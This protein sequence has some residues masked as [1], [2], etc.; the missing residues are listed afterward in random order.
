MYITLSKEVG[1]LYE[2][3]ER[4]ISLKTDNR[5]IKF[6]LSN[7]DDATAL[8]KEI[9]EKENIENISISRPSIETIVKEYELV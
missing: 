2:L 7:K 6:E 8:F 1:K 4:I 5:N 3:D 9:I